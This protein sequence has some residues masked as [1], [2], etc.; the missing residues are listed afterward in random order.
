MLLASIVGT[1]AREEM[2]PIFKANPFR[3]C[4]PEKTPA[5]FHFAVGRWMY[6]RYEMEFIWWESLLISRRF[7][8][9]L[10]SVFM[11]ETPYM[12]SSVA[13]GFVTIQMGAHF[14][15]RP[16]RQTE[17]RARTTRLRKSSAWFVLQGC[18]QDPQYVEGLPRPNRIGWRALLLKTRGPSQSQNLSP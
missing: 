5:R 3:L 4:V 9:V 16:F 12:Q 17:V 11:M 10:C 14:F 6:M 13:I 8:I 1:D 2:R 18:E 7:T 15:A